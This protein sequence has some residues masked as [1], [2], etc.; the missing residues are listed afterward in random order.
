MLAFGD[1]GSRV[2]SFEGVE[3]YSITG[4]DESLCDG[5]GEVCCDGDGG[6]D[7]DKAGIRL[8]DNTGSGDGIDNIIGF[9]LGTEDGNTDD[10][11]LGSDDSS[12]DGLEEL[13]TVGTVV[14]K[15]PEHDM[16]SPSSSQDVSIKSSGKK[17][18]F[19]SR[20]IAEGNDSRLGNACDKP[21]SSSI[22]SH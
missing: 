20:I 14:A 12:R 8:G 19:L 15:A 4:A 6:S 16:G 21:C 18:F 3:V 2:F 9:I 11:M 17:T 22:P 1:T 10:F 13:G 5:V 7:G